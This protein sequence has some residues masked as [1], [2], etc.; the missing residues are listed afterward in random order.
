MQKPIRTYLRVTY[1]IWFLAVLA[2][3]QIIACSLPAYLLNWDHQGPKAAT[4]TQEP[5]FTIT[6]SPTPTQTLTPSPFPSPTFSPISSNTSTYAPTPSPTPTSIT[7]GPNQLVVDQKIWQL[8]SVDTPSYISAL[9][10]LYS[11][12]KRSDPSPAYVFLRMN[13]ECRTGQSL[14]QAYSGSD[15]GLTFVHK[16]S[17]YSDIS[18][19]D[20]QGH[21]YLVT[22]L[23]ACW[24]A[25]PIPKS[26]A[27]DGHFSLN[28]KDLNPIQFELQPAA[29]EQE[30]KICF[31]SDRDGTQELFSADPDGTSISRLTTDF[32]RASEPAWSPDHLKIAYVT[33]RGGNP[34]IWVID[35]QGV[36]LSSLGASPQAEGAPAWSPDGTMLA[37][38]TQRDGNWEIYTSALNLDEP[39]NLTQTDANDMYPSWSPDGDQIAF[40]SD[41]DGRWQIFLSNLD[42]SDL[43]KLSNS[44]SQDILP[45]WSPNGEQILYWSDRSGTWRLY[46]DNLDGQDPQALTDYENPGLPISRAAWSPDGKSI[47]VSLLRDQFLQLYVLELDGGEFIRLFD[48]AANF[49]MPDW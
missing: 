42:G 27:Q 1:R 30:Q 35:N 11:P 33:Q 3:F 39:K 36:K 24:L 14:I 10:R 46:V 16:Q 21:K 23:G 12:P 40:Q 26:R 8:E 20:L 44:P 13:F 38:H 45:S 25:A 17:G 18:I 31:I 9:N 32:S 29:S 28:F 47:L 4:P 48:T 6:S 15:M 43:E 2:G 7:P 34:D 5:T 49:S 19:Q 22:L 37:F 41:R